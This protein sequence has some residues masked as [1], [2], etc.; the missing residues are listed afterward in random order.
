MFGNWFQALLN[1]FFSQGSKCSWPGLPPC[2]FA[3]ISFLICIGCPEL[4]LVFVLVKMGVLELGGE[5][6]MENKLV[7]LNPSSH[8]G[9]VLWDGSEQ[10]SDLAELCSLKAKGWVPDFCLVAFLPDPELYCAVVATA[11]AALSLHVALFILIFNCHVQLSDSP[12]QLP[13]N[14]SEV[15]N[16]FQK[17][18]IWKL[19]KKKLRGGEMASGRSIGAINKSLFHLVSE[20]R[21]L[22]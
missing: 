2:A 18:E 3:R 7:V 22:S 12:H 21:M 11:N 1:L 20:F 14:M 16:T 19:K 5:V 13:D 6:I 4:L 10:I 8:C 9:C 15:I 17:L